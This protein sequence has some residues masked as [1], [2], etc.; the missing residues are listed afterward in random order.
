[1]SNIISGFQLVLW[2]VNG[3][4][5]VICMST[6]LD[7]HGIVQRDMSKVIHKFVDVYQVNQ[8]LPSLK[9]NNYSWIFYYNVIFSTLGMH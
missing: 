7:K 5:E 4:V 6:K 8:S 9:A 1:M 3:L 2:G